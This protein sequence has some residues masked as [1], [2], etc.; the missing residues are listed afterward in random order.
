MGSCF[1]TGVCRQLGY[2]PNLVTSPPPVQPPVTVQPPLSVV[3]VTEEKLR[4]IVREEIDDALD[5]T[6]FSLVEDE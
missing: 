6:E 1:C 5:G 3:Y 4:E 2:C